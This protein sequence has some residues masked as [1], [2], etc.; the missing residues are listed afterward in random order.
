MGPKRA[1][2]LEKLRIRTVA[3]LLGYFP[4]RYDDFRVIDISEAIHDE[5]ATL[6]GILYGPPSIRWYSKKKYG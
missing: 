3:D 4:Y 5:K 2:D 1:E 6:E